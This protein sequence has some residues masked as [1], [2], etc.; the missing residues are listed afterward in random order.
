MN[1]IAAGSARRWVIVAAL[2]VLY[3]INFADKTVIGLA[4]EPIMREMHLT[5]AE[6][7]RIASSFFLLFA[8]STVVV[9]IIANHV[10][11]RWIL[12]VMV[13]F[14]SISQLP[15]LFVTV[16]ATL[17]VSRILLGAAEG[18]A[19]TICVHSL[20]K[21]FRPNERTL[22]T[23]IFSVGGSVGI[24]IIA[25]LVTWVIVHSGWRA[26]FMTLAGS[27]LVWVAVWLVVGREGPLADKPD[28]RTRA[29]SLT[30][31][32]ADQFGIYMRMLFSRTCLGSILPGFVVYVSLTIATI[33]LPSYLERVD[34]YSMREVGFIMILPSFLNIVISPLLGWWA[35]HMQARGV[36]MRHAVGTLNG[37][38][39]AIS[40]VALLLIP[41]LT[42]RWMELVAVTVA[43][44]I[45][46]FAFSA[47]VAL[48]STIVP[49]YRRGALLGIS[50][51]MQTIAGLITPI[52]MGYAIDM[53]S[54]VVDGYRNGMMIA[55]GLVI[56]GGLL[57]ALLIDPAGDRRRFVDA[58]GT[59]D[60]GVLERS[61][62]E[63]SI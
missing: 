61:A 47:G 32:R 20:Y 13:I 53:S 21:W 12:V 42:T 56:V 43:F 28:A 50:G 40:G 45:T 9:G 33:W 57:G 19:Y 60:S 58:A 3:I 31:T 55:G 11:T 10:K 2:F 48:V 36:S 35:Q 54:S 18:P 14:W 1:D 51:A 62:I 8:A 7:G 52:A 4:A 59:E 27:G 15:L 26:A 5:H 25:P 6:F 41:V 30:L 46:S 16:P 34:N 37:G 63:S 17:L 49:S 44:S 38:I 29:S 23:A 24:G 22:P 39:V